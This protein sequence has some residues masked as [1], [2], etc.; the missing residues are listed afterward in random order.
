MAR[1]TLGT[2]DGT[3][4]V[5][6][7][8]AALESLAEEWPD[9][10][11]NVRT[12]AAQGDTDLKALLEALVGKRVDVAIA[13][14][15]T[16]PVE[17]PEEVRLVVVG[18]RADARSVL[19]ARGSKT[20]TGLGPSAAIG[21]FSARDA[22]FLKTATGNLN[23]TVLTGPAE[24]E[25]TRLATG[26]LSALVLPAATMLGLDLR[27]RIDAF[28]EV[29]DLTP[30]PGQGAVGYLVRE[31]DDLAF[32]TVYALQHRPSFD[33]VRA[34]RAFAAALGDRPVGALATVTE[35][36]EL[37]LL[38]AV[39]ENDSILQAT[40]TGEAREAEDLARELANDVLARGS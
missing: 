13:A 16:L 19:V 39:I 9:L 36:G 17:L 15:E 28:L 2:R 23:A 31:D 40:V 30:A 24:A 11:L 5:R 34:E 38:G 21:V 10:H 26:E 35:D 32:E 14:L 27:H 25:L 18:R 37:T 33:R 29:D 4:A 22:T 12:V 8:R 3:L 7:G 1:I 6:H 20:L